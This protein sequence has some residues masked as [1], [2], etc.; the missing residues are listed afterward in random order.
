MNKKYSLRPLGK[1]ILRG[2]AETINIYEPMS[3]LYKGPEGNDLVLFNQ[4]IELYQKREWHKALGIFN[5]VGQHNTHDAPTMIYQKS[6]MQFIQKP[7]PDP[8]HGD[9]ILPLR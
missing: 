6:C 4:A 5:T 2:R 1:I 8:W 7:P 9:I 3:D